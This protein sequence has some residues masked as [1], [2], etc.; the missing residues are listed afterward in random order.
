MTQTPDPRLADALARIDAANAEDPTLTDT[1]D[2]PVAAEL[3]YSQRM[4]AWL[5]RLDADPSDALRVAVRAQ[6]LRR[7]EVSR[8]T[9]P[10]GREGYRRWRTDQGRRHAELASELLLAAGWDDAF[11]ARVTSLIRKKSFKTDPEAQTLEDAAC[12]VF[13]EHVLPGFRRGRDESE[14][15]PILRKTW[16]KMSERA[17][18]FA[19][20]L[21]LAP[22]DRDLVERALLPT[23]D[24]DDRGDT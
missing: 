18:T 10:A 7:W 11:A 1:P 13:L 3:L 21:H 24:E 9:Y 17:R 8:S 4:T 5:E 2:G 15:L 19:L 14:L 20:S 23:L 16:V 12:L 6:H 22:A